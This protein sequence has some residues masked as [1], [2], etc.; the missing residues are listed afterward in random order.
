M[1]ASGTP[2]LSWP[3]RP[4]AVARALR[5]ALAVTVG[6]A[7]AGSPPTARAGPPP[8][9]APLPPQ[10]EPAPLPRVTRATLTNGLDVVVAERHRR[11]LVALRLT[12]PAGHLLAP[13]GLPGLAGFVAD[14]LRQGTRRY[15]A[16]AISR[17]LEGTGGR[18]SVEAGPDATVVS[19]L[20]LTRDLALAME[21]LGEMVRSPT[22]SEEELAILRPR[23]QAAAR[24]VFDD[25]GALAAAHAD[26]LLYGPGQPLVPFPDEEGARRVTRED[27]VAFHQAYYTP[28]GARLVV[29]GDVEPA[30][31]FDLARRH[32]GDWPFQPAVRRSPP[33]PS[34]TA[35][36]VRFVAWPG[37]TQARI[38]LRQPGPAATAADWAAVRVYNYVLGGGGFASRLM[39]AV[40]SRLGS[41]YDIHSYY[42]AHPFPAH[43]VL[44]TYTRNDEAWATLELLQAELS[45]FYQTGITAQELEDAVRF[46]V[47]SYPQRL[48]TTAGLAAQL[49]E[50]LWLGRGLSWVAEWPQEVNRLSLEEVNAAIRRHFRPDRFAVTVLGDPQLLETAPPALWGAARSTWQRLGRTEVPR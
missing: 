3:P 45:R 14:M 36:R 15:D 19:G 20:W 26:Q 7:G 48:E 27:L 39:E 35:T 28:A 22:F 13:P 44:S 16:S 4:R 37:Q 41:T 5:V 43:W 38:E 10:V 6:L 24:Q 23:W 40:R 33:A 34:L 8:P 21:L 2:A 42:V 11:P 18:L 17:L 31:V 32:L 30:A 46:Y 50:A 9:I 49:S 25:P 12:I 1:M 29:A 47:F